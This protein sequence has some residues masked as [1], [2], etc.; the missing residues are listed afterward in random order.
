MEGGEEHEGEHP[1]PGEDRD[2][3]HLLLLLLQRLLRTN[4]PGPG[5]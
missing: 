1:S 3:R 4:A 5:A 2:D